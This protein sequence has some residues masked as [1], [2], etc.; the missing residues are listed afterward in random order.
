M[1]ATLVLFHNNLRIGD[2]PALTAAAEIGPVVPLFVLDETFGRALGSASRWWLHR[3]LEALANSLQELGA[4]LILRKGDLIDAVQ[5]L[6]QETGATRVFLQHGYDPS[7][8]KGEAGLHGWGLKSDVEIKR[9]AG[10]VLFPPETIRTQQDKPYTVFSP[11][12]RTCLKQVDFGPLVRCDR[13]TPVPKQPCSLDLGKLDLLPSGV[14][15]TPSLAEAFTPG[16]AQALGTLDAYLNGGLKSYKEMRDHPGHTPGTSKLSAHLRF[17]EIS[18]RTIWHRTQDA[19]AR[20]PDL[21]RDGE[22]FLRELGWR[23]FSYHLLHHFPSLP[24]TPLR[25]AFEGFPWSRG[26]SAELASW[27]KG[28]TGFPIVD[29]GMRQL[30]QT[31]WMHNRVRMI[32]A[33]FLVKELLID[34]R[35]G[36][37]WFW[38]TLVDADPA[39]NTAS[40]Q[41][42]AGCGAD[43]APYFRIFNPVLQGEKFDADGAYVTRFAPE[44]KN[45]PKKYLHKP[46]EAPAAVLEEA[47]LKLG[48]DYPHPIV[49]RK[50]A[51]ARA[52]AAFQSIKAQKP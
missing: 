35:E 40:W 10:Q 1:S 22:W 13:L 12:W 19:M 27:K 18:P 39:S 25:S 4:P 16:E 21:A 34:W 14:D 23:D 11:F 6:V 31:G 50:Q 33:S 8:Q 5:E 37:A 32:V 41:W 28:L 9:F 24:K 49:D 48:N 26:P 30:W 42:A 46:W 7:V 47:D 36:E 38:D 2:N 17:G 51:R 20:D 43:A 45:L 44:L 29:A 15:W 3:S 52:L